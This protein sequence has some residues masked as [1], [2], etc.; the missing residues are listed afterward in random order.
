M[1]AT[2]I[3]SLAAAALCAACTGMPPKA[4]HDWARPTYPEWKKAFDAKYTD[5]DTRLNTYRAM[6][7]IVCTADVA[8]KNPESPACKCHRATVDAAANCDA[9][10]HALA[11]E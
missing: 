7:S 5:V 9:F 6:A 1:R 8:D 11:N 10:F 2:I 4:V 3:T